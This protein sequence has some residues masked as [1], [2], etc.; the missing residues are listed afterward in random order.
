M[1]FEFVSRLDGA[2]IS[3]PRSVSCCRS[4][5]EEPMPPR[6][7]KDSENGKRSTP[8]ARRG[9]PK[10]PEAKRASESQTGVDAALSG[11][12]DDETVEEPEAGELESLPES[13]AAF[14]VGRAELHEELETDGPIMGGPGMIPLG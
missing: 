10:P 6:K 4:S 14:G 11:F 3:P 7:H 9:K 13:P 2:R 1:W 12:F 5:L 8:R